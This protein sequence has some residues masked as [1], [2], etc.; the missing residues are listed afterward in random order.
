METVASLPEGTK[1]YLTQLIEDAI[2]VFRKA[3]ESELVAWGERIHADFAAPEVQDVLAIALDGWKYELVDGSTTGSATRDGDPVAYTQLV[4]ETQALFDRD[5]RPTRDANEYDVLDHSFDL[6]E[7][8]LESLKEALKSSP[9]A[10]ALISIIKE[11]VQLAKS[12]NRR[13][14]AGW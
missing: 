9:H 13:L 12:V 5:P 8:A 3:E 7:V 11:L 6:G 2:G 14:K 10:Q 1:N 4:H